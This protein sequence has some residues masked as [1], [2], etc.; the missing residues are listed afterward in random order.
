[1]AAGW[2]DA[3]INLAPNQSW[4]CSLEGDGVMV[5]MINVRMIISLTFASHVFRM[6]NNNIAQPGESPECWAPKG[7]VLQV[8]ANARRNS[9]VNGPWLAVSLESYVAPKGQTVR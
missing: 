9:Q 6:T 4:Y 8:G 2:V 5:R 3:E 7:Q 1:M